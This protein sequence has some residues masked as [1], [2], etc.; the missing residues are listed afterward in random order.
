MTTSE[1][2]AVLRAAETRGFTELDQRQGAELTAD[3]TLALLEVLRH[4]G[5]L[6]EDLGRGCEDDRTERDDNTPAEREAHNNE[7]TAEPKEQEV[8]Q[9]EPGRKEDL[10][11]TMTKEEVRAKLAALNT[12]PKVDVAAIMA[13]M[14]YSRLSDVPG[15]RYQ[16]LLDKAIAAKES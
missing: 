14:G 1:K 13:G 4:I 15:S 3:S 9:P 12:D 11:S 5:L 10:P 2:V 7:D 16:E 6:L 8:T